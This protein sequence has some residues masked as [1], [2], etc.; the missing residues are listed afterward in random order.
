[1]DALH[2][3]RAAAEFAD[4]LERDAQAA[5]AA[6]I[7]RT[8]EEVRKR[9]REGRSRAARGK[10]SRLLHGGGEA[11]SNDLLTQARGEAREL[12]AARRARRAGG[13]PRGGGARGRG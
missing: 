4:V 10:W 9:Q 8:E 11:G 3:I 6:Q 13:A 2:L 7:A 12:K 1:M 5:S